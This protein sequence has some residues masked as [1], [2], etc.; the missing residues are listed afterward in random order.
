MFIKDRA[1][2]SKLSV[3]LCTDEI[4]IHNNIHL[5]LLHQ[6]NKQQLAWPT[7]SFTIDSSASQSQRDF[8]KPEIQP[9]C[10]SQTTYFY[11]T[12]NVASSLLLLM[13]NCITRT[14]YCSHQ[15]LVYT[16]T[17]S[18][19]STTSLPFL[20]LMMSTAKS[21]TDKVIKTKSLIQ[22]NWKQSS[23]FAKRWNAIN[24]N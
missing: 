20:S 1:I 3:Q 2:G 23:S 17:T 21:K 15:F 7:Y 18:H 24:S 16:T 22:I 12:H 8:Q 11:C 5:A 9:H 6:G 4:Q 13:F 19:T 10:G 14:K